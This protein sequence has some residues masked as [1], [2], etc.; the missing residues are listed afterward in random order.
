MTD[1]AVSAPIPTHMRSAH[2]AAAPISRLRRTGLRRTR[3]FFWSACWRPRGRSVRSP[4]S[5]RT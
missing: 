2:A 1:L 5:V 4:G 3:P